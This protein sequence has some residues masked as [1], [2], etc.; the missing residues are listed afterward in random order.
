MRNNFTLRAPLG[1]NL[2]IIFSRLMVVKIAS[3]KTEKGRLFASFALRAEFGPN[4]RAN[5]VPN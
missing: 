5:Y 2:L 4:L 1:L 3:V